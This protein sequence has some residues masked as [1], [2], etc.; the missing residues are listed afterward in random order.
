MEISNQCNVCCQIVPGYLP[1][2]GFVLENPGQGVPPPKAT[3]PTVYQTKDN[4]RW[5]SLGEFL[6][7]MS[8]FEHIAN[9]YGNKKAGVLSKTLD[10]AIGEY[11]ENKRSP[12]RK[13]GELDNRGSHFYLAQYWQKP[14]LI[15]MKTMN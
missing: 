5:D 6:A 14:W 4:L 11:L 1:G 9:K 10:Q 2:G 7:L 8:S 12:G 13:V 3:V 15:K